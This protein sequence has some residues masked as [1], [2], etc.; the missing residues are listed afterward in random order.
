MTA[1]DTPR[2]APRTLD[3]AIA[4]CE[5]FAELDQDRRYACVLDTDRGYLVGYVDGDSIDG[6]NL[7][8]V[9]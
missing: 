3:D 4:L 1:T 7:E 8:I 9:G 6:H 5:R 2:G